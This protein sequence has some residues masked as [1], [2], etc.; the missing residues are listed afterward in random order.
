MKVSWKKYIEKTSSNNPRPLLVEAITYV[1][2]KDSALDF[3]AGALVDSK[4]LLEVG[5]K[6]VIA[7]DSDDT[8]AEYASKI[9]DPAFTYNQKT[10]EEYQFDDDTFDLINGQFAFSFIS[11]V[12]FEKIFESIKRSLKSGGV[13]TG[14]I[15]GNRDEW[16]VEDSG[17]SFLTKNEFDELFSDFEVLKFT[18]EECDKETALGTMKHWHTFH[19]IAKKL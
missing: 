18:E 19:F 13:I 7:V 8:S 9:I 10:F 15:F 14:Q 6:K 5:F 3:G 11:P 2:S 1:E 4:Y 17:K 16:N 12:H